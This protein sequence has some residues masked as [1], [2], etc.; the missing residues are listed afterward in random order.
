MTKLDL[1]V[2]ERINGARGEYYYQFEIF[3][4]ELQGG[5]FRYRA[6]ARRHLRAKLR[7]TLSNDAIIL[8]LLE[9]AEK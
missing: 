9:H 8:H 3:G 5:F 4:L 2:N 1:A 7:K 6:D